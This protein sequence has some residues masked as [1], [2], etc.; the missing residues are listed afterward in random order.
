MHLDE[1]EESFEVKARRMLAFCRKALRHTRD[2]LLKQEAELSEAQKFLTYQQ[3]AD[4]LLIRPDG[5][6]KGAVECS[7]E[8]IH[9]FVKETIA[10][11]PKFSLRENAQ[12]YFKKA[13]KGKRSLE[14]IEEKKNNT[15]SLSHKLDSLIKECETLIESTTPENE[16]AS[17]FNSIAQQLAELGFHAPE[18]TVE[19]VKETDGAGVAYRHYC[20][21]GWDVFIGKTDAQNDEL[22]TKFA[23]PWHL[24]MHVAGC[25]GSHVVIRRDKNSPPPPR[26]I[27]LKAASLAVWFSKAKHTSSADVNYTEARYV[28]KRRKSPPG[29]VMLQ[30]HKT[31]RVS[32]VSPQV[33]FPGDYEK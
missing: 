4:S 14:I 27:L 6:A 23:R 22:T 26:D 20:F 3:W 13:K 33:Y 15:L 16:I 17:R 29:E 32:P 8:N 7:I 11:N 31:V 2:K 28:H 21:D 10:L 1:K 5:D 12:L 30:Q 9:T 24:W 25:A 19:Q 18:S